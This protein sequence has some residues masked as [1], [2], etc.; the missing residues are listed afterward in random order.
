M[1][2]I[3]KTETVT[4]RM[5]SETLDLIRRAA[6]LQDRSVTSF[7]THAA[8]VQAE[9]DILDQRVLKLD[10]AAFEE[11]EKLLA[12]PVQPNEDVVQRFRSAPKWAD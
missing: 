5:D 7:L 11:V 8:R 2:A 4:F 12:A 1:S 6:R 3:K 9:R 10:A